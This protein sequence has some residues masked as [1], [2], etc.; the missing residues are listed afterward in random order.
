VG[1]FEKLKPCLIGMETCAGAHYWVKALRAL[2]H[3]VKLM[4]PQFVKP[5]IKSQ[6]NDAND[7]EGIC[8]TVDRPNM[9]F[10]AVKMAKQQD[11]QAI[12]RIRSE[13]VHQRMA[14]ANQARRF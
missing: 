7:A 11:M 4:A 13:L 8:E 5:Y 2:C 6:K 9:R 12:H 14:K 3:M 1:Y 10:V